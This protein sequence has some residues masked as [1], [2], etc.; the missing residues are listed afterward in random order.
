MPIVYKIA[1]RFTW[2]SQLPRFVGTIKDLQSGFIHLSSH[3]AVRDVARAKFALHTYPVLASIDLTK[4]HGEVKWN[5]PY[6]RLYG[7]ITPASI[8]WMWTLYP[9]DGDF[10][11][12]HVF[13]REGELLYF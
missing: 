6:A 7:H 2:D 5:G 11:Y 9:G 13:D 8:R 1:H 3:G 12:P 10:N 4:V